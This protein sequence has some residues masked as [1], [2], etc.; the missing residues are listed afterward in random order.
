MKVSAQLRATY[1]SQLPAYEMLRATVDD[2][3]RPICHKK[4]WHYESR[5]KEPLSYALKVDMGRTDKIKELEDFFACTV[6]VRNNSE[7]DDAIKSIEGFAT[8]KERKPK[9]AH[10]TPHR[11]SNFD[12]DDLRL[13]AIIRPDP[14]SKPKPYDN[15]VFEIQVKTFLFHAWSMATH[16]L[17][18]KSDEV[19]WGKERIAYQ[20]RAMLEHA[21]ITIQEAAKLSQVS[22]LNKENKEV[23]EL[24]KIIQT[25]KATWPSA[26]LPADI[27][28]LAGNILSVLNETEI[29]IERWESLLQIKKVANAIPINESPYQFSVRLIIDNEESAVKRFA[30]KFSKKKIVIYDASTLPPWVL[31]LPKK[32]LIFIE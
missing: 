17:T 9:D 7:I 6:V 14:S 11:P 28:R 21:E 27:R 10:I 22:A 23:A 32:N 8:V 2:I 19:S 29:T 24:K 5:I 12:F 3:L 1:D 16:D 13:Y 4:K 30:N 31:T 15:I 26:Q 18:Y 20:V 25:L